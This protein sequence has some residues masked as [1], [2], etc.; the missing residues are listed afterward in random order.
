M[1]PN[2]RLSTRWPVFL[3]A[4]ASGLVISCQDQTLPAFSTETEVNR[5]VEKEMDLWYYWKDKLPE[6]PDYGQAPATFFGNLLYTFDAGL[7]PDGDRFSWIQQ[8]ADDLVSSLSGEVVTYGMEYRVVSVAA[9]GKVVG[10]VLY[11]LPGSPAAVAG[12]KRGDF[13][14][15]INGTEVT[16]ANYRS[17]LSGTSEKKFTIARL[18]E[19]ADSFETSTE[20]G[21]APVRFQENPVHY[22]AVLNAGGRKVGY[23]VY[24]QFYPSTNG[25]NDNKFDRELESIFE[26]FRNQQIDELVLDLRYNPGGYV[27]SAILL[28][29]LVAKNVSRRDIFAIKEYNPEISEILT[30]RYGADFFNDYFSEKPQNVGNLIDRVFVLTS[31]RTASA[32][33]LLINGLL[34][35]MAVTVVGETTVGKNVGSVTLS[36]NQRRTRWGIQPIVSKSFNSLRQSNYTAGFN[37]DLPTSERLQVYPYGDPNDPLLG[38]AL[39]AISGGHTPGNARVANT[40]AAPELSFTELASSIPERSGRSGMY[41]IIPPDFAVSEGN[42]E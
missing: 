22:H 42:E 29:S 4:V 36:D 38:A 15:H 32:S 17:L 39:H 10:T 19:S 7:R 40:T 21:I 14:T 26:E 27:S 3:L 37:P 35:Y 5:W 24:H 23:L 20:A 16:A 13:F 41:E 25:T 18:N 33:E 30:R 34:P 6:N 2:K 11:V 9:L 1:T 8:S 28:G 31:R 12:L